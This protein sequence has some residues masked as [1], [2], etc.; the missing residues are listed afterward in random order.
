M[1]KYKRTYTCHFCGKYTPKELKRINIISDDE[2][3]QIMIFE[4]CSDCFILTKVLAG[5]E[6]FEIR[7]S[8]TILQEMREEK[9][10]SN[11]A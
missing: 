9:N 4:S 3:S 1:K 2:R 8:R 7:K 11:H 10:I 6:L 5:D